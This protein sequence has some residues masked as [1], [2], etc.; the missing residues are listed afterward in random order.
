MK[1]LDQVQQLV[2]NLLWL[3]HV[4]GLWTPVV[5]NKNKH[6]WEFFKNH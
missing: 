5:D 3:M 4:I 2:E 1:N 6:Q